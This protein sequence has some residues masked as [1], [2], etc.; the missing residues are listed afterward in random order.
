[1]RPSVLSATI[2]SS[3]ST[4]STAAAN[5]TVSVSPPLYAP[6]NLSAPPTH[7]PPLYMWPRHSFR[8]PASTSVAPWTPD[9]QHFNRPT[10]KRLTDQETKRPTDQHPNAEGGAPEHQRSIE[11]E[12]HRSIAASQQTCLL[13]LEALVD[14]ELRAV[15]VA[16]VEERGPAVDEALGDQRVLVLLHPTTRAPNDTPQCQL[17]IRRLHDVSC[18]HRQVHETNASLPSA[19]SISSIDNS[20]VLPGR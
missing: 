10:A 11:P 3:S 2:R 15:E 4:P 14:E 13:A 17:S 12:Q 20:A 5:H 19:D 18:V 8:D 1:M 16:H 7:I 9:Q 6:A